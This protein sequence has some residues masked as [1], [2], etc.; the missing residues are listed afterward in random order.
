MKKIVSLGL[1]VVLFLLTMIPSAVAT[2]VYK[3]TLDI[4]F[5]PNLIFSTYDVDL[6]LNDLE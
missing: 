3:V 2:S 1:S 5:I 6:Y 4:D